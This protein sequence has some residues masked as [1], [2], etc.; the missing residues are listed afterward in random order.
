MTTYKRTLLPLGIALMVFSA[1]GSDKEK[2]DS[3]DT[4]SGSQPG[5]IQ[6]GGDGDGSTPGGVNTLPGTGVI[7]ACGDTSS[8][9]SGCA[10]ESYEGE[11]IP[12]DIYIM[13]DQSASMG[14][15]IEA[16]QPWDTANECCAESCG[17][18]PRIDPVRQALGTFLG[19]PASAGISVGLGFFGNMPLGS[20]SC[21]ENN[22]SNA[23]V[24]V[25]LLPGHAAEVLDSLNSV[26]PTGETPT[27]AAIRGACNYMT[28]WHEQQPGHKKVI[29]LV[30]DGV[31][32]APISNG[33]D[34]TVPDAA[35]AATE[36]LNGTPN[37]PTYVLGV[38]QALQNLNQIAAAGGTDQAYL[39]DS[40][41]ENSV[42]AALNAIRADAIIPCT[43][44]IPTPS[45]GATLNYNQVNLGICDA[46][47]EN[48]Q[49]FY[50]ESE[51]DCAQGGWYYEESGSGRVIQLCDAT[52]ETVAVSGSKL[53]FSLGC[54]TN[55]VPPIK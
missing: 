43:L 41:V 11:N 7:D 5:G 35:A 44:E 20:T 53:F 37:M 33:C 40:D 54:D 3:D 9:Q 28:A 24:G 48:V 2:E 8:D 19:D 38:G 45:N 15:V 18:V 27:G 10:G 21:D 49:T 17:Q 32:E 47:H 6:L 51:A 52:C 25:G 42:L 12:L 14:C 1:C 4:D 39:V 34:P 50:V 22:Y 29:L 13:F 55:V 30:T 31:P 16:Q 46:S 26:S 23:A 36:C